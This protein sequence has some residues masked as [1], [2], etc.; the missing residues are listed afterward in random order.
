MRETTRR[1][2]DELDSRGAHNDRV[3]RARECTSST[4]LSRRP[5]PAPCPLLPMSSAHPDSLAASWQNA[6]NSAQQ[7]I[8]RIRAD[9]ASAPP[10]DP[11]IT[12]VGKVDAELL[13]TELVQLL[14]EPLT[15]AFNLV[16]VRSWHKI[17]RYIHFTP[18][19]T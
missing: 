10:P 3:G 7:D 9:I 5:R 15:K 2:R 18:L 6:W 14:K 13:D 11:R 19:S 1:N 17:T 4:S 16:N 8:S 12:R